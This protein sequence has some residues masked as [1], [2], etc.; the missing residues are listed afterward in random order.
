MKKRDRKLSL[1]RETLRHLEQL[2][3]GKLGRVA[4]GI[5]TSCTEPCACGDC[6]APAE[7]FERLG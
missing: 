2:A 5:D 4:A 3:A 7:G 6:P 1:H